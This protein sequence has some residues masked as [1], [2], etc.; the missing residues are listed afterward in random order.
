[1]KFPDWL[2]RLLLIAP[3]DPPDPL[4]PEATG[5]PGFRRGPVDWRRLYETEL[6]MLGCDPAGARPNGIC[7]SG[8]GVRS[9]VT[10]MG[11]VGCLARHGIFDRMHYMSSV[12]GGGYAAAAVS[13]WLRDRAPLEEAPLGR[14][15]QPG[16]PDLQPTRKGAQRAQLCRALRVPFVTLENRTAP[17]LRRDAR[18]AHWCG[19]GTAADPGPS[20]SQYLAQNE[21]YIRHVR[22]NI[23]YLMPSGLRSLAEGVYVI[24]RAIGINIFIWLS[25]VSALF[26]ALLSLHVAGPALPGLGAR[27]SAW[28]RSEDRWDQAWTA[29]SRL[30]GA[31]R[32]A[33]VTGWNGLVDL[34]IT[35][36]AGQ[37]STPL[38]GWIF[39]AG[40]GAFAL[41]IA[42]M[43]FFGISTRFKSFAPADGNR[44][45]RSNK[46]ETPLSFNYAW[47]R[48]Q[49]GFSA[50]LMIAGLVLL[51]LGA[52]PWVL[53][54][55]N[56]IGRA[57]SGEGEQAE[58]ASPA[59][60]GG[61]LPGLVAT[62]IGVGS[63]LFAY[64]RAKL[65][66]E[67]GQKTEILL[68]AGSALLVYGVILLSYAAAA[69]VSRG[70]IGFGTAAALFVLALALALVCNVND[71]TLGRYYRD[72][73]I[74]AFMPDLGT[75]WDPDKPDMKLA[76]PA[77]PALAADR[78]RL[79]DLRGTGRCVRPLHLVNTNVMCWWT[80]DTRARRRKGDNFVLSAIGSGSD[81]TGWRST[82]EVAG[83]RLTLA[84]AIAASGAAVNPRGG[85]AGKGP[86]TRA[87]VTVAMS[88]LSLR[89]GYWLRWTPLPRWRPARLNAYGNH[90]NPPVRH[91]LGAFF[92]NFGGRADRLA[93]EPDWCDRPWL[94]RQLRRI[95]RPPT[96]VELSDGAHFENLGLYE[97]IRR[98]CKL[99]VI[100]EAGEDPTTS[101]KSFTVA[102]RR[103]REDFG[104]EIDFDMQRNRWLASERHL[105]HDTGPADLV[106]RGSESE[107]PKGAEYSEKG[108]FLAS[109]TYH[110][111]PRGPG[112][113]GHR[114]SAGHRGPESPPE[115][116]LIVYLKSAMVPD[117]A[118]TTKG[119][120]GVN[121]DFPY[122]PTS[123]Q[124]FTPE[125]FEAYRDMGDTIARQMIEDLALD[126]VVADPRFETPGDT[127]YIANDSYRPKP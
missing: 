7:L 43:A 84:S 19:C 37:G 23:S 94:S 125:Q 13:Q 82:A 27:L 121:A 26:Y 116:G 68:I 20:P 44:V 76:R 89:L 96:F 111:N 119:Y 127:Y 99:I 38:F 57:V 5:E 117:V 75:I 60:Q 8:G 98:R 17:D 30:P 108:Y 46:P 86:T 90:V 95:T 109:V 83:G 65:G 114:A 110:A 59:A 55:L 112:H 14:T 9:A 48:W 104:A 35:M 74:E 6:R 34:A 52:I 40:A 70:L 2:R 15:P 66:K 85:F 4:F 1:M 113:D 120:K 102:I 87:V 56:E 47:R 91:L 28:I 123:N 88:L 78:L 126:K 77:R 11:M 53:E 64:L 33:V 29:L 72:R 3:E 80:P 71:V 22:A 69:D 54:H 24:L 31:V 106:A 18:R 42:L 58:A 93:D 105:W 49:T 51:A 45:P 124:F 92:A 81:I 62:L 36:G 115:R 103:V 97:L 21:A 12:S 61:L 16:A 32:D 39:A 10:C 122:D 79:A 100:C 50:W 67:V 73:L 118:A 101:Y 25:V 107:F 63:S 41:I